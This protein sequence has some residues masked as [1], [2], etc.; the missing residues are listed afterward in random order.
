MSKRKQA[1]Q[2]KVV[3]LDSLK[4]INLHAAGLDIGAAEIWACVPQGRDDQS[5]KCFKTFTADLHALADWLQACGIKTV[6]M[7]STGVYWIP[8]YEIL[9]K[10][11][12]DLKL[13]NAQ[14]LKRVPGR[15]SDIQDCQWIQQL[16]TYGLLQG[17]FQ[18]EP[19]IRAMR[20]YTRQRTTLV[21]CRNQHIQHMQKALHL[22]NIQLTNV[23]SDISGQTG[24]KIIRAIIASERDP[25]K[26]AKLRNSRCR[27]SE[28]DI[29]KALDG[30][31]LP[32]HIFALQQ[33]LELYDIFTDKIKA[34]E[35]QLLEPT[36]PLNPRLV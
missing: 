27:K 30:H 23:I 25:H 6:A 1:K 28:T 17:S 26:L 22:M 18:P 3:D 35:N 11:G 10:R 16:H 24:L 13:V 2:Q 36:K 32:E 14:H 12:I 21:Q 7:E 34:C 29:A 5:V 33:A 19:H 20:A 8:I 31:Y 15:K 9:E 4:Q